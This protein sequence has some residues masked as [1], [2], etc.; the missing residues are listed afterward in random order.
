M[1]EEEICSLVEDFKKERIV[2]F[3]S[4]N[5]SFQTKAGVSFS[6]FGY[7]QNFKFLHYYFPRGYWKK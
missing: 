7:D 5:I 6:D 1:T 2:S 4:T 3:K